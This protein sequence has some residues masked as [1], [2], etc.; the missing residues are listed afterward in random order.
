MLLGRVDYIIDYDFALQ[1]R[2]AMMPALQDLTPVP[3]RGH[4]EML[5]SGI[6][7][8]RTPGAPGWCGASPPTTSSCPRRCGAG[9][10]IGARAQPRRILNTATTRT[11]SSACA[12]RLLAAAAICSTSA[13]FCWVA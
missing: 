8:P 11:S 9:L 5:I 7:C 3:L 12:F 2:K 4:D 6:A 10:S 13:A 1:Q